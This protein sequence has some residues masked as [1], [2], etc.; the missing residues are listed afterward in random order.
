[1][2]RFE[3]VDRSNYQVLVSEVG[4]RFRTLVLP[5]FSQGK[6]GIYAE[7]YCDETRIRLDQYFGDIEAHSSFEV[8]YVDGSVTIVCKVNSNK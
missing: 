1:M 7:L 5:Y 8:N 4:S 2:R 3:L 6:N